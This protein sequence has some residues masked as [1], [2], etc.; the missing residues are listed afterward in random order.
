VIVVYQGGSFHNDCCHQQAPTKKRS[1]QSARQDS[2]RCSG[3]RIQTRAAMTT[4]AT[5]RAQNAAVY[6]AGSVK[7]PRR[8]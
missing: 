2:R 8:R 6:Q 7:I 5:I 3:W 4:L 1:S